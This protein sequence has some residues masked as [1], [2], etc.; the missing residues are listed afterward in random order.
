MAQTTKAPP[1]PCIL[2][3]VTADMLAAR[4]Y[5][6]S[7]WE[8]GG[9]ELRA[10]GLNPDLVAGAVS[11]FDNEKGRRGFTGPVIFT[12]RLRRDGGAWPDDAAAERNAIWE[13]LPPGTCDWV[14]LEVDAITQVDEVTL[15][16]LRSSGVKVL[17]SH[18]A[19]TPE[20]S[21]LW[22]TRLDTMRAFHPDGVKFAVTASTAQ[23][24]LLL[25]F[26]RKVGAEFSDACVLGMG[27][28]GSVTRLVSPLL[29]CA[30]TY[31]FIGD[32]AVAP[33]QLPVKAMQDFFAR[34]ARADSGVPAADAP[35]AHWLEWAAARMEGP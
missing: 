35:V 24:P 14:D 13:S 32:G 18:H 30:L 28:E 10:D 19:F 21:S 16:T 8:C 26:A 2:G 9:V 25:E 23:I 12:L 33:G 34:A 15:D 1:K 29:G 4:Q 11:D 7:L 22:E 3:I 6:P 31:G 5:P 27:A 17:L 20:D